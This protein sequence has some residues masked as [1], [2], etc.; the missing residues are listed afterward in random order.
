MAERQERPR[1][2]RITRT[3][4]KRNREW[5]LMVTN[6]TNGS[7]DG[8]LPRGT[9]GGTGTV[10][11]SGKAAR[12]TACDSSNYNRGTHAKW[13][14]ASKQERAQESFCGGDLLWARQ[15]IL[16]AHLSKRISMLSP[17]F[18]RFKIKDLIII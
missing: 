4:T 14:L 2:T 10:K 6:G 15:K 9:R 16:P 8:I 17:G 1:I 13:R 3:T 7:N 12:C 18:W 5:T 11:Q